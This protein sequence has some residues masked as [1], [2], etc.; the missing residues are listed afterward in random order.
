M[1][2]DKVA[3]T[4]GDLTRLVKNYNRCKGFESDF[5]K[6]RPLYRINTGALGGYVS[7]NLTLDEDAVVPFSATYTS[8]EPSKTVI[9]G[10]SLDFSSPRVYDKLFLTVEG[11]YFNATYLGKDY[12]GSTFQDI[13]IDV[14]SIRF[15]I[16]L[17]YNFLHEHSTPFV[18]A[19]MAGSMGQ[20]I[21]V[22]SIV[23]HESP[24]G[25]VFYSDDVTG[26][27]FER[28]VRGYWFSAGYDQLIVGKM[29]AFVEFR[30][31]RSDGYFGTNS[32]ADSILN[33][34][35]LLVGFR[36]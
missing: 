25:Q 24:A 9:G 2:A 5:T 26:L 7:S 6:P 4:E 23:E 34:L 31:E 22:S 30:Y 36:F 8:F 10:I 3:Y 21:D 18:K 11:W 20:N 35:S 28:K 33:N 14:T 1:S 16:G 27:M 19:G 17:R 13:T 15:F 32:T 12:R 29:K